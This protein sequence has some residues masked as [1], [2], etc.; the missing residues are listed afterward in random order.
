MR[1]FEEERGKGGDLLF[2][3]HALALSFSCS[4]PLS[5]MH[6]TQGL[7]LQNGFRSLCSLEAVTREIFAT[8]AEM[9][10]R[11]ICEAYLD[12]ELSLPNYNLT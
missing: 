4:L 8:V 11:L 3:R 12:L 6:F 5:M 9:F 7:A 2:S 1:D 10:C